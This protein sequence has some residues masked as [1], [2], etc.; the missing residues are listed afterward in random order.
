MQGGGLSAQD[1]PDAFKNKIQPVMGEKIAR[2]RPSKEPVMTKSPTT[3]VKNP[4][5]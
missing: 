3:T 2:I 4:I 5:T 1:A